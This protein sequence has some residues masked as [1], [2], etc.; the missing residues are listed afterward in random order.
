MTTGPLASCCGRRGRWRGSTPTKYQDE[1][2][3]WLYYGYRYYDASTG[4]WLSRD[5]LEEHGGVNLYGSFLN[6]ALNFIDVLGMFEL[7]LPGYQSCVNCHN[8]SVMVDGNAP[9]NVEHLVGP[10][11]Y[12]DFWRGTA[13]TA[14]FLFVPN[15][16]QS[17]EDA[18]KAW[19]NAADPELPGHLRA[20]AGS[21][22]FSITV[23]G[24]VEL[25]P[26]AKAAA[27][28]IKRVA[29]DKL[30]ALARWCARGDGRVCLA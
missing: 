1:E 26:I 11:S 13:E 24:V 19:A 30:K 4:R 10:K 23:L 20:A 17:Y 18:D 14:V 3:G 7:G 5:P 15:P 25:V 27:G 22:G 12:E 6:A 29:C 21:L 8:P 2:T 9:K 28:P 16:K